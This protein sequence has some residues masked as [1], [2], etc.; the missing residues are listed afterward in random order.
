MSKN[1]DPQRIREINQWMQSYCKGGSCTYVDYFNAMVD[2][3]GMMQA[4]LADDGLHPNAKGYRIMAPI[5]QK[6]IEEVVRPAAAP[7]P[8]PAPEEKKHHL[9]PFSRN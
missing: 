6:A 8:A 9:N 4:D 2:S 7:A 1:H 3:A 5:A